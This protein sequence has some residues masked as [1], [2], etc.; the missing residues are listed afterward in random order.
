[1]AMLDAN[2][3][4]TGTGS[5]RRKIASWLDE[6]IIQLAT[7]YTTVCIKCEVLQYEQSVDKLSK[8]SWDHRG[9]QCSGISLS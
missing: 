5:L 3:V 9:V 1:M 8:L 4:S 2:S 7:C 6:V